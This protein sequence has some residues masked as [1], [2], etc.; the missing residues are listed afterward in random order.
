MF[1][2]FSDAYWKVL[3]IMLFVKVFATDFLTADDAEI[4]AAAT[5]VASFIDISHMS[6]KLSIDNN[7]KK[8]D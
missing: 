2:F 5:L 1:F 6:I 4:A 3:P 8:L 7:S